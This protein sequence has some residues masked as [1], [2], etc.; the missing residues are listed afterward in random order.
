MN[1]EEEYKSFIDTNCG[2]VER[3]DYTRGKR[4]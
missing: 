4:D 1:F 2:K 3:R